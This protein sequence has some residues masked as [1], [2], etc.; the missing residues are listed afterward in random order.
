MGRFFRPFGYLGMS[1][2]DK[3]LVKAFWWVMLAVI[4]QYAPVYLHPLIPPPLDVFDALGRLYNRGILEDIW[5]S[6]SVI[7]TA[8]FLIALPIGLF[9][10]YLYTIGWFR[11]PVAAFASLRN[12]PPA[13][14]IVAFIFMQFGGRSLKVATMAFIILVFFL[15]AR[16][17]ASQPKR[18]LDHGISMR[19][20]PWQIL[21][22]RVIMGKM[23]LALTDFVPCIGMGWAMLMMVEGL[24]RAE[25]GLGD[26]LLQADKIHN[27]AGI[28]AIALV[29]IAFGSLITWTLR[30]FI[31]LKFPYATQVAIA[32]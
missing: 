19:M 14:L 32:N 22:R 3:G 21:W 15:S 10:S 7:F 18:E 17:Y 2:R 26:L 4:W 13:A 31:R 27:L 20:S 23:H 11:F 29:G 24:S 1:R 6:V 30:T 12:A 5:V 25:G 16:I 28:G 8:A 9:L